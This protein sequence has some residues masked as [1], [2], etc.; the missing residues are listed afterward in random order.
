MKGVF[1]YSLLI[2]ILLLAGCSGQQGDTGVEIAVPVSVEEIKHKP[3][4]EFFTSTGTVKSIQEATL[5][6]ET[7]GFYR[8]VMN[9]KTKQP[10]A[11]GD[12]VENGQ[13]IIYLDNP[14]LES[15]I[16]IESKVLELEV[17]QQELEKQK[18]L[19][20]KGGA[21]YR[22]LK[23]AEKN[24][25]NAR[26]N[27]DNAMI[28]LDKLKISAPFDGVIVDLPY[29]TQRTKIDAGL[30]MVQ[31]MNYSKLY[32][33]VNLPGKSLGEIRIDQPVRVMNYTLPEDT[34][35][36]K[37]TQVSPALDPDTRSF[38]SSIV[39][40]NPDWLLRPGM[41]TKAEIVVASKDS[42]IVIPK[43]I[44]LAKRRGKTVFIVD[45]GAAE[46]RVISTGLENP[47]VVEVTNGLKLNDRLVVKGFETLRHRS[48]VRIVR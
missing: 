31:I 17:S 45:K 43:E 4:E 9:P 18:S 40:A 3:I 15:N 41:F 21:T 8:L 47:E 16:M 20:E 37:V 46:E 6:S 26:Y 27:Y 13:V 2:G 32:M 19:Y 28:Q 5:K 44:I 24:H 36:G 39:I 38:K 33:E 42:A 12:F 7:S 48:K 10:F 14:E 25:M 29:Y 11:L 35:L 30:R 23:N 1:R 22:E 34:L